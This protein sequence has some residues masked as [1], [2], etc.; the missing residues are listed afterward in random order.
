MM[1]EEVQVIEKE[2]EAL[3]YFK[4]LSPGDIFKD[5]K[6]DYYMRVNCFRGALGNDFLN[7]IKLETGSF[8]YF[9]NESRVYPYKRVK[10][11]VY[12]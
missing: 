8:S 6:N 1:T 10:I 9:N 12:K 2:E 5:D 4:E 3:Y 7:V 11:L